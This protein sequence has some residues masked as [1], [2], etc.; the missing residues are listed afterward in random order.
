MKPRDFIKEYGIR[1]LVC[2]FS[3]GRSS[4][5][6]THYIL[7][8]IRG[9][10]SRLEVHVVFVDTGVMLPTTEDYV[11]S[12][13]E[14]YGWPLTV[15]KPKVDFWR[16]AARYGTPSIKRR[17][18][19]K[20]LKLQPIFDFVKQL[21]FQRAELL[22]FR[23]DEV[24]RRRRRPQIWYRRK[25]RSWVYYPIKDW[26]RKDV[27][28]YIKEHGL[29]DPPHY[30]LGLKETCLCGAYAHKK[31]WMIIKAHFP[32]FFRK[33]VELEKKRAKW[34]RTAFYDHGPL[35]AQELLKQKT[36]DETEFKSRRRGAGGARLPRPQ[37][38]KGQEVG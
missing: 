33:F 38:R 3:G 6:M 15:L 18:C 35:S 24:E 7:E 29:P 30:R 5:A 1:S 13:A 26:T 28:N 19:C 34:G 17:W 32:N 2:C 27:I 8:E 16:Y 20:I 10:E 4:L 22:G 31:E 36:L 14:R 37:G 23:A 11:R 21:P 25:T 9:I 12:V